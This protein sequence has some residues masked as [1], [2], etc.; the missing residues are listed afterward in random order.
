M[1]KIIWLRYISQFYINTPISGECLLLHEYGVLSLVQ[2]AGSI[3]RYQNMVYNHI[4]CY[5]FFK[6]PNISYKTQNTDNTKCWWGYRAT[7]ALLHWW[8]AYK[9]VQILWK[10]VWQFLTKQT[11]PLYDPAIV[12]FHIYPKELKTYVHTKLCTWMFI[13]S[14]FFPK[15]GSNR[16]VLQ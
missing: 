9:M 10:T 11:I 8:W 5:I 1:K 12:F 6:R 15:L 4:K 3:N 13:A 16:N 14:L 7:I 2:C